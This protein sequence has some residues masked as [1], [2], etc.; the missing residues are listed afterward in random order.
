MLFV[1]VVGRVESGVLY[2]LVQEL[3]GLLFLLGCLRGC[4]PEVLVG[5]LVL[6]LGVAPC[7]VWCVSLLGGF[8]AWELLW[9]R[10][11]QKVLASLLV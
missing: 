7:H 2:F 4:A 10:T 8:K 5:L 6:K 1:C 9:F 3:C 11:F